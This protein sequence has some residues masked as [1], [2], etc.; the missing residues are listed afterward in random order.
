MSFSLFTNEDEEKRFKESV[1]KIRN[2][3]VVMSGKG[4]VGKSSVAV[5]LSFYLAM[6]G[7]NVGIMDIDF[8]GPSV[9]KL[10]GIENRKLQ[11]D[12][13]GKMLPERITDSFHAVS[14]GL[15]LDS[16]D[17]PVI[18]RGPMK[19]AAI[20]QFFCDV[21]W[22]E[23]DFLIIDSPPGTG[24]EPLTIAQ[25]LNSK[26][27]NAIIV[28]TP[29]EVAI[30]D[31]RKSLSF[32]NNLGF[33]NLGIVVNMSHFVCPHCGQKSEIFKKGDVAQM[34]EDHNTEILGEIPIEPLVSECGDKGGFFVPFYGK[35]P[36]G[37]EFEKIGE[38]ILTK[39]S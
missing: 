4:G 14:I 36:A 19:V 30:S 12:S 29:Q 28:T 17:S 11:S 18:W 34:A 26:N 23:L 39:L 6:Q 21:Q 15:F 8:H 35:T 2:I 24:D 22:G 10:L 13:S 9:P 32:A 27:A 33:R 31:V 16:I 37:I 20:K 25:F 3:I 38:K 7:K 5:N 1:S